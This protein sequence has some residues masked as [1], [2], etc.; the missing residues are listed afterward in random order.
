M[1]GG[2][3]MFDKFDGKDFAFWKMQI[4]DYLY[5]KN[6]HLP[7]EG[8]KPDSME[9]ADWEKLDRQ[10]LGVVRLTLARN[11]AVEFSRTIK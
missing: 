11:V 1:E 9:K 5:S 7:L 3:I 2:K 8:S 6:M 10:A 4:T